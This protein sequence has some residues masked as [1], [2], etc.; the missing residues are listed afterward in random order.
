MGLQGVVP[1]GIGISHLIGSQRGENNLTGSAAKSV[2]AVTGV[3]VAHGSDNIA[4]YIPIF[5]T[6]TTVGVFTIVAVF[7]LMTGVW[8]VVARWFV[9]HPAW[10]SAIQSRGHPIAPWILVVLGAS[11]VY[12]AGTVGWLVQSIGYCTS[13]AAYLS[14]SHLLS[15]SNGPQMP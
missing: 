6:Q 8:L 2:L 11:M 9:R 1:A 14:Q 13:D 12:G 10:G 7:F 4:I 5:A 15:Q 3:T